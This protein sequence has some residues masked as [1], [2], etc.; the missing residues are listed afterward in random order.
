LREIDNFIASLAQGKGA[1]IFFVLGGWKMKKTRY[2]SLYSNIT[3][4]KEKM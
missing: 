2:S 3:E 1:I 4:K